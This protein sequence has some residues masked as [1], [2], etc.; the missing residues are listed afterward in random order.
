MLNNFK[1]VNKN[2]YD[3]SSF[4]RLQ[5]CICVYVPSFNFVNV[6]FSAFNSIVNDQ[7]DSAGGRALMTN[8]HAF[9]YRLSAMVIVT[10]V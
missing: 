1:P 7:P 4:P 6:A 8:L 3:Y 5:F 10:L 2:F 9:L